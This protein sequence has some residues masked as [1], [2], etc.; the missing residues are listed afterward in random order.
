MFKVLVIV[1]YEVGVARACMHRLT[2]AIGDTMRWTYMS[3]VTKP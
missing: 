1:A 2:S 3:I